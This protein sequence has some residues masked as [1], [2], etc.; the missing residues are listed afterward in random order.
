MAWKRSWAPGGVGGGAAEVALP[1]PVGEPEVAA[2]DVAVAGP[3]LG[4]ST[5]L[6]G[7]ALG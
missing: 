6:G 4:G 5:M 1:L 2:G 7:T 3:G